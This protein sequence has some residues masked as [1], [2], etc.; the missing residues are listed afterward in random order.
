MTALFDTSVLLDYL[1]GDKRAGAVFKQFDYRALS[2]IS[3]VEVMSVAPE[4]KHETTR[5]FLR[6]FERLSISEAIA[7]E[8]L[9]LLQDR[10]GLPFHRALTWATALVNQM[11]YV[12]VDNGFVGKDEK[13]ILIPYAW[14]GAL[15]TKQPRNGSGAAGQ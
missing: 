13:G 9:R 5:A 4:V 7:D 15:R 11:T 14:N 6:S 10:P 8:A 12:T 1:L 2:V 3:W